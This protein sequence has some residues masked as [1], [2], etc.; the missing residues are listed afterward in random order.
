MLF[1]FI[2]K[3]VIV[4]SKFIN[5]KSNCS[6]LLRFDTW[7]NIKFLSSSLMRHNR[8]VAGYRENTFRHHSTLLMSQ[9]LGLD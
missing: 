1:L 2:Y 4:S 9:I 5:A 7:A 8:M 6:V 3:Y